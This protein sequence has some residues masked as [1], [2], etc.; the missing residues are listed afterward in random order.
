[1]NRRSYS[2]IANISIL[3][4]VFSALPNEAYL[5]EQPWHYTLKEE[6]KGQQANFCL[7]EADIQN[8]A[9]IFATAG[10]RPGYAALSLSDNCFIRVQSFTPMEI[11]TQ[12]TIA[13]GEP[14]EYRVTFVKVETNKGDTQ[15]LVTTRYVEEPNPK[16]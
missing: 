11:I 13:N 5:A 7:T 15:Y 16:D 12:I 14:N 3:F 10:P 9:N 1:M 6:V 8:I 4:F 2:T